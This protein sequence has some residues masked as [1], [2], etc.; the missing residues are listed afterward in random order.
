MLGERYWDG[1][2]G[3]R[4][5][6]YWM[7]A[8]L[9][10]LLFSAGP[11]MA[12]GLAQTAAAWREPG[13]RVASRLAAAGAA[14]VVLADLSQMSRAEVERIW[15][16]FVPWL[17]VATATLPPRLAAGGTGGP[18]RHGA[19]PA[20][21][22]AAGLV[23]PARVRTARPPQRGVG[24][25]TEPL[26][27]PDRRHEPQLG[28]RPAGRGHDVPDVAGS[29][30]ARDQRGRP[31]VEADALGH[32][33]DRDRSAR[34]HVVGAADVPAGRSVTARIASRLARATSATCTKSRVW[35]AVLED[36]RSLARGPP[37]IG[38]SPPPRRTACP[39]AYRGRTRC[40]S[41]A[42]TAAPPVC[43]AQRRRVVLLRHLARGVAAAWVEGA[44][45][46]RPSPRQR[47][48]AADGARDVE[49][50]RRQ[51][52]H[53]ARAPAGCDPCSAQA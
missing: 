44:R 15:L 18:G 17:L 31:T 25:G 6:A 3:N 40:G 49:Q 4:P 23:T 41:A 32:V 9:A 11:M 39:A 7:W 28:R 48:R 5:A 22:A 47:R 26:G 35:A 42:T 45:P 43:R 53:A 20:A 30:L 24:E 10:A 13:H 27:R 50:T 1:V 16:P 46:R 36:P 51:V 38:T 14:M 37:P 19:R 21:P 8:N 12:A 52:G 33:T 29:E 34:A 2:A